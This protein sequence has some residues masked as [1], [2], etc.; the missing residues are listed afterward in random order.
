MS[1]IL[2]LYV[3]M[4]IKQKLCNHDTG[5]PSFLQTA[6]IADFKLMLICHSAKTNTAGL[7][8]VT[9]YRKHGSAI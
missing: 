9:E 8:A 7:C 4:H 6:Y 3:T 2:S 5:S 1:H